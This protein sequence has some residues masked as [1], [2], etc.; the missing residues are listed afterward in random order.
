MRGLPIE[1]QIEMLTALGFDLSDDA[2]FWVDRLS[3]TK[4]KSHGPLL[5]RDQAVSPT[6][7]GETVYVAGLR[8]LGWDHLDVMRAATKAFAAE[9]RIYCADT[10]A[11]YSAETPAAEMLKALTM[12]E[13][14]RR[15]DRTKQATEGAQTR[16]DRR[17]KAGLAIARPLWPTMMTVAQIV[18]AS[19]VS[20]NTLYKYLP[21]REEARDEAKNGKKHV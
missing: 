9:C 15:R 5:M 10:G 21:P 18:E 4:V 17:I 3:R 11:V 8:V 20:S 16:R 2:T 1:R 14:A 6:H 7:H 19:G 13:E 12:A